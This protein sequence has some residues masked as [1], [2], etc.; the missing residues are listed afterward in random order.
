MKYIFGNFFGEGLGRRIFKF[1][2]LVALD[3]FN[4]RA[5]QGG[6]RGRRVPHDCVRISGF[7]CKV[8]LKFT[9]EFWLR[10]TF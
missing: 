9:T 2:Q 7:A 1:K 8:A 10:H 6:R 4:R 5:R 3:F